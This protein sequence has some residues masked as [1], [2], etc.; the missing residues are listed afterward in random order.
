MRVSFCDPGPP[1]PALGR[2]G[3]E[4]QQQPSCGRLWEVLHSQETATPPS[5]MNCPKKKN[6]FSKK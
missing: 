3:G 1:Q 5:K 6:G 4:Q 2:G